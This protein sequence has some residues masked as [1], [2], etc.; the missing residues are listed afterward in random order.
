MPASKFEKPT[1][2]AVLALDRG[3][4]LRVHGNSDYW[5]PLRSLEELVGFRI[6][7]KKKLLEVRREA[8]LSLL[9]SGTFQLPGDHYYLEVAGL[10]PDRA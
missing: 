3:L 10:G 9:S 8:V 2:E 6:L 1:R 4:R 5:L 7:S